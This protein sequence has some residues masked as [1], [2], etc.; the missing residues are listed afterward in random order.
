MLRLVLLVFACL[1]AAAS[2]SAQESDGEIR[3][4]V[5]SGDNLT[6]IALAFGVTVDDLLALNGL[7]AEAV[8]WPGQSLVIAA[9]RADERGEIAAPADFEAPSN[10]ERPLPAIDVLAPVIAADAPAF[11]PTGLQSTVCFAM[12]QDDNQNGALDANESWLAADGIHLHDGAGGE[13]ASP[14]AADSSQPVCVEDLAPSRYIIRAAPPA[15]YGLTTAPALHID[16]EA[17]GR[18][19]L[20]FGAKQGRPAWVVPTAMPDA[21]EAELAAERSL[22]MEL[23]GLFVMALAAAALCGGLLAALLIRIR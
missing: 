12:F 5:R 19:W 13:I 21:A 3:Y 23:S 9:A 7:D 6:A 14:A 1:S 16:L 18:L 10:G 17:G 11:D 20:H 8:L 2:M 22:L 4:T 15:G